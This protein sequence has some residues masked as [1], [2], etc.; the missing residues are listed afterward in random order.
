MKIIEVV[1]VFLFLFIF[2]Q[3]TNA[4]IFADSREISSKAADGEAI[5]A[6]PDECLTPPSPAG[7]VPIP[8]PNTGASSDTTGGSKKVK[9]SG[10]E[11]G[12]KNKS[13]FNK[14]TSDEPGTEEH[15]EEHIKK[16]LEESPGIWVPDLKIKK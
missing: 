10:K 4:E 11:V 2:A 12:L 8:Y 6:F 16:R 5:G 13:V 15:I 7:A 14:S 9:I 3:T 1:F